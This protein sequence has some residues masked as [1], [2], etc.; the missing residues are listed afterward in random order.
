M[1]SFRLLLILIFVYALGDCNC[2]AQA[3]NP[4][5]SRTTASD[6]E[7][8]KQLEDIL[9]FE[10]RGGEAVGGAQLRLQ[11]LVDA[12]PGSNVIE[13]LKAILRNMNEKAAANS[14][15]IALAY[16]AR[17]HAGSRRAAESR[18]EGILKRYPDYSRTDEVL[19][20]LAL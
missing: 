9:R 12:N 16:L 19:F 17:E 14:F 10:R 20:Q 1:R 4:S 18:F 13:V 7:L 5:S 2:Q 6:C 8:V 3:Q 15:R 11:A